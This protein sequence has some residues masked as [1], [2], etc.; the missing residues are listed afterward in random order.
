MTT[1]YL[2]VD[3]QPQGPYT[4]D[5]LRQIGLLPNSLVWN[6]SMENWTEAAAV[7]EL[8]QFFANRHSNDNRHLSSQYS[9]TRFGGYQRS[10]S[11]GEAISRFFSKYSDF[12]GRAS[13]SEYWFAVL[14]YYLVWLGLLFLSIFIGISFNIFFPLNMLIMLAFVIPMLSVFVRR[15][16]DTGRSGWTFFLGLIPIIGGFLLLI[17]LCESS[18]WNN[19][20][21]GPIPNC[22]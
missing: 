6:D 5:E 13:R 11:F 14:F 7:P 15:M 22:E 3:G 21:Y 8:F 1:F 17:F 12:T 10:V 4:I 20:K 2:A 16:H 9:Q 18:E 19:N